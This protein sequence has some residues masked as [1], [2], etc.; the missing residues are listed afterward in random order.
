MRHKLPLLLASF[1]LLGAFSMQTGTVSAVDQELEISI[2]NGLFSTSALTM[3]RED[4]IEFRNLDSEER[5]LNL[6]LQGTTTPTKGKLLAP[7]SAGVGPSSY[8]PT[9]TLGQVGVWEYYLGEDTSN[10]GLLTVTLPA[11]ASPT[12]SA[13]PT[14][15]SSSTATPT[16]TVTISPTPTVSSSPTA[17]PSPTVSPTPTVSASPTASP[18]VSPTFT[19][20]PTATVTPTVVPTTSPSPTPLPEG[21]I[22]G[23]SLFRSAQCS[24]E[25]LGDMVITERLSSSKLSRGYWDIEDLSS[26]QGNTSLDLELDRVRVVN[27]FFRSLFFRGDVTYNNLDKQVALEG[28]SLNDVLGQASDGWCREG[29]FFR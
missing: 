3:D 25:I 20:S 8:G 23:F 2:V 24:A 27:L 4:S 9:F 1:V 17:S 28:T 19:P 10:V 13:T 11:T 18:T 22:P 7:A 15:T 12:I 5:D 6:R 21:E 14:M 26:S 16:P 29:M